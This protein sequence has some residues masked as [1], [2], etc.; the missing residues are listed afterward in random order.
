MACVVARAGAMQAGAAPLVWA[1]EKDVAESINVRH[2]NARYLPGIAL[3]PGIR[4]TGEDLAGARAL[5]D[6]DLLLL[7]VPAQIVRGMA[8]KL[9]MLKKD[10]APAA[11]VVCAKGVEQVSCKLMSEVV[12]EMLPGWP[13]AVLSG[14]SFAIEVARDLP[15]A[16]TLAATDEALGARIMAALGARHFRLYATD[17]VVG[18]QVG[19]AIKNVL[20]VACG[21]VM[22][23]GMGDNARAAL[24]TRGLAGMT[25]LALA[26][27]A[28]AETL[29][30]LSGLGDLVLTCSSPQSR[31]MS[32]GMAL[33][34]G[35][36]LDEILAA[37]HGVT[38]G[39]ATAAAALALA[40]KHGVEMP[41]VEAVAAILGKKAGIEA[42]I[43]A[44]LARPMKGE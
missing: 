36:K 34:R 10:R 40:Q 41:I 38:E 18:A 35:Q 14:P 1:Y 42:T 19:G 5:A 16:L 26:L 9:A 4:A 39:V 3:D 21:I 32:L 23:R 43:E 2:E 44:L 20:A 29:M 13:C 7:A 8:G 12:E 28:R 17:D 11:L 31:N 15:A 33:G 37:R 6:C 24:I 25:R 27:G 30:G 22:G